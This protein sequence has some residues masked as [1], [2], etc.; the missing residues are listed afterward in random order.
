M[1]EFESNL[2]H[3]NCPSGDRSPQVT[4]VRGQFLG[5]FGIYFDMI[6]FVSKGNFN[7]V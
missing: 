2:Y 5:L 1:V 7:D 4:D 6:I 3:V